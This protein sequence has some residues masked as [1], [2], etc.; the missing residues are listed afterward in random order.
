MREFEDFLISGEVKKQEQNKI[1][2][3]ALKKSAEKNLNF[4]RKLE[5]NEDNAE[6]ILTDSYDTLR[7]L[8]EAKLAL[9]G[10][11]SYSHEATILYLKKFKEFANK[12]IIFLD[13]LRKLRNKIKYYGKEADIDEAKKILSFFNNLYPKIKSLCNKEQ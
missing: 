8:I 11:K 2:S 10:Y 6:H 4:V 3:E 7:E 1:L 12:E 9:D 5:L 13:E